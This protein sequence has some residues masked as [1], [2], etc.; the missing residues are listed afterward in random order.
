M[1]TEAYH[2]RMG[3]VIRFCESF[4]GVRIA[5]AALG[6]GPPVVRTTYYLSNLEY[7]PEHSPWNPY[8]DELSK[9]YTLV[10]HDTRG[11]GLSDREVPE[12][13]L[14]AWVR[15]LEAVVDDAGLDRFALF[16]T[17]HGGAVAIEYAVRH[18]ER[19]SGMVL[20]GTYARGRAKRGPRD[21]QLEEVG[22]RLIELSWGFENDA[23]KQI[24]I[25]LFQPSALPERHQALAALQRKSCNAATA[26]AL[27]GAA[28]QTD[29]RESAA[30]VRCPTLVLHTTRNPLLPLEEG[31][32]LASLVPGARFVALDSDNHLIT[33]L[34][35][36]WKE[37]TQE[38]HRFLDAHGAARERAT[39]L[40]GLTAREADILER[41]AQ[42]LDNAQI[43]A[44]LGMSE[45]TVRNHVTRIFDKL[46]A[47]NRPQAIVRAR[48]AGLGLGQAAR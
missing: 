48:E 3:Q 7:D 14:Q 42:G 19:V 39:G 10:C 38:L 47:E 26:L 35:P 34:E 37:F 31:R 40:H 43:A 25:S 23:F 8:R 13:G 15:D 28:A 45:K 41:I 27:L 36:A 30:M 20:F 5:Y 44:H 32:L 9:R 29:V 46:G 16:G 6:S 33:E 22:A 21:I 1:L 2:G 24:W 17:C 4:D 11:F 18:P 12:Q